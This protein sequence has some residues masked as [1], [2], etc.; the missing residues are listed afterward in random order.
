MPVD[1]KNAENNV[2]AVMLNISRRD[3]APASCLETPSMKRSISRP[4]RVFPLIDACHRQLP[5]FFR[6]LIVGQQRKY[7]WR[8][9]SQRRRNLSVHTD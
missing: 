5:C 6:G 1:A 8:T 4:P 2:R 9:H 7:S 3:F